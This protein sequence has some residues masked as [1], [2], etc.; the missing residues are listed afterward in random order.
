M[1]AF[2]RELVV[3]RYIEDVSWVDAFDGEVT[4]YN[5]GGAM[6]CNPKANILPLSN[7]GREAHTFLH[8]LVNR[9]EQLADVTVFA[10]G[11]P[12]I[13]SPDFLL[14]MNKRFSQSQPL[15]FY[16]LEGQ[17]PPAEALA[18]S[19]AYWP[20]GLR[21]YVEMMNHHFLAILPVPYFDD[22]LNTVIIP[23]FVRDYGL[24]RDQDFFQFLWGIFGISERLPDLLP[25]S[26]GSQMS[27][28]REAIHRHPRKVY[29]R[30]LQ[31]SV[32][33]KMNAHVIERIWLTLFGYHL[34]KSAYRYDLE[35][36]LLNV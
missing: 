31:W 9:Y 14:L 21:V 10:Q 13:H 16:Y 26:F 1:V 33:G 5:K 30:M 17:V 24:N 27:V 28:P 2:E 15:S 32:Q 35:P 19:K 12:F 23:Q 36:K 3:A 22:G 29:E 34:Q 8:H 7:V 6:N 20:E 18:M 11:E 4:I 25:F